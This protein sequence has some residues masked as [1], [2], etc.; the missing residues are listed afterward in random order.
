MAIDSKSIIAEF[1]PKHIKKGHQLVFC[2]Q[3]LSSRES[4]L[5][6]L[7]IAT[8]KEEDWK[9]QVPEYEFSSTQLSEWLNIKPKYI[10]STLDPV[11][12][13]LTSR[14]VGIRVLNE[15]KKVEEFEYRP[16]FK[17]IKYANR[18][19]TMVPN[20]ALKDEYIEYNHGFALINTR[21]YFHINK[22]HSKRLYEILSRFKT[23]GTHIK[24]YKIYELMGLFG[25]LDEKGK[26][27]KDKKSFKITSVFITRCIKDSIKEIKNNEY[28]KNEIV[29]FDGDTKDNGFNLIRKGRKID[30]IEF[31]YRWKTKKNSEQT[32][33]DKINA[34]Q[35]ISELEM[36]R[37]KYNII[38]TIEEMKSLL[39][40][41]EIIERFDISE[42]IKKAIKNAEEKDQL[43][44]TKN[45]DMEKLLEQID[46]YKGKLGN[47]NYECK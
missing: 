26:L 5:F 34:K 27:K 29:F 33:L 35:I 14:T 15:N 19:L 47:P 9:G 45:A 31:L 30:S 24:K 8:M 7:M 10:S 23:N 43:L 41:Y 16:I 28:T 17:T 20:D 11:A 46:E 39:W 1:L 44:E 32:N 3:D 13:R 21:N 36:K 37:L 2:R 12:K 6:A 40:A 18:K 25:L 22:E 4:D 38:L 42:Q